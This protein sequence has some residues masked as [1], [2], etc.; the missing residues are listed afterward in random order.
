MQDVAIAMGLLQANEHLLG[1]E[2][3]GVI[4]RLGP[5]TGSLKVGQRVV[6]SRKGSFANRVQCPI[7]AIH[8]I[9]DSMSYEVNTIHPLVKL[10]L[11]DEI[12]GSIHTTRCILCWPLWTH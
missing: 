2:G 12:T 10:N 6:V 1:L 8:T 9:P 3:G 4:R 7:E 5:N 11:A